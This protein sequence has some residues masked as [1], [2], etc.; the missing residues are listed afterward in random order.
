MLPP[1]QCGWEGL[2][3]VKVWA[4]GFSIFA[5][6]RK[7]ALH[8][9]LRS[10]WVWQSAAVSLIRKPFIF[11]KIRYIFHVFLYGEWLSLALGFRGQG[12]CAWSSKGEDGGWGDAQLVKRYVSLRTRVQ[13][14]STQVK[15][16]VLV[17]QKWGRG[18]S[19]Q[20]NQCSPLSELKIQWKNLS[21]KN[22][23]WRVWARMGEITD[24]SLWSS[25]V[26]PCMCVHTCTHRNRYACLRQ[27]SK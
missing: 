15:F 2:T 18:Q 20:S 26:S 19:F 25:H 9:L 17:R 3:S 4:L 13:I 5:L 6:Q 8:G 14:P 7:E 12:A 23:R 16:P 1:A 24:V 21:Q 10:L 11:F 27:T 22:T